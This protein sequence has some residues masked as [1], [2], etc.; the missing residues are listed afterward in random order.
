MNSRGQNMRFVLF[1]FVLLLFFA[2]RTV[3]QAVKLSSTSLSFGNVGVG[4]A[5]SALGVVLTNTDA[6]TPLA[7]AGIAAS[8]DYAES[9]NCNGLVKPRGTCTLLI[10]F[11]PNVLGTQA[12]VVTLTDDAN[13]SPQLITTTGNGVVVLG[14]SKGS[15][16][17][18]TV[19][20]GSTS[21]PQTVTVTNNLKQTATIE[22][23]TSGDYEVAGSGASP[24]P[25][26]GGLAA[27][28]SCTLAVTFQPTFAATISG[29]LTV[30]Q[31]FTSTP[32]IVALS[33]TGSGGSTPPLTFTPTSVSFIATPLGTT[34]T[35]QVTV[36]NHAAIAL[37]IS[38]YSASGDFAVQGGN[39]S[40]CGGLLGAG[41]QC[42]ILVNFSPAT[43]GTIHG[44]LTISSNGSVKTQVINLTGV[45]TLP[46]TVSPTS[47][48]FSSLQQGTSASRTVTLTNHLKTTL[49][50]TDVTVSGDYA[51][52]FGIPPFCGN[53]LAASASCT[54]GVTFSPLARTGTITGALTV[55]S[56][57]SSSPLVVP[58]TGSAFGRLPRFAYVANSNDN[59]LS[60]YSVNYRTGQL[61]HNGYVLTGTQ[62]IS[63]V[64]HPSGRFVYVA[65]FRDHTISGFAINSAGRLTPL[66]GSPFATGTR[67]VSLSITPSG[68]FAYVTN[69]LDNTVSAYAVNASTGVLTAVAGSPF[70][71][72]TQPEGGVIHPSGKFFYVANILDNT[73]SAYSIGGTGALTAV[74][75]SPFATGQG[76]FTI[77]V[78]ASGKFAYVLNSSDNTVSAYTINTTTGALTRIATYATDVFPIR[79]AVDHSGRFLY[80][81]NST[82]QDIS[83]YSIDST[84]GAL[85]PLAGSPFATA[86]KFPSAVAI[87]ASNHFLYSADQGSNE[88][89]MYSI[90]P[91]TGALNLARIVA[92][93]SAPFAMD[94]SSGIA[95][96]TYTP[97]FVYAP[98]RLSLNLISAFAVSPSTGALT[99]IPSSPFPGDPFGTG[100]DPFGRFVYIA[101]DA[102]NN[103]FAYRVNP[104]S[105][106]LT[107]ILGSPVGTGQLPDAVAVDPSGRF[108]YV[109]NF[110][111]NS[112]S[113]YSINQ[114]TGALTEIS[115]SP[116]SLPTSSPPGSIA[117]DPTGRFLYTSNEEFSGSTPGICAFSIDP[118]SG[119][120]AGISGSPFAISGSPGT[121]AIE[122]TGR[123]ALVV[124]IESGP[125]GGGVL[126]PYAIDSSTGALTLQ[127]GFAAGLSSSYLTVEPSG[128]VIFVND[129]FVDIIHEYFLDPLG[130]ISFGMVPETEG[131]SLS[132]LRV[133]I[134]GQFL[135]GVQTATAVMG[136]GIDSSGNLTPI[137]GASIQSAGAAFLAVTGI[138]H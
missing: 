87:D 18:G 127:P 55:T 115:G 62:P 49:S 98:Q 16:A 65:N 128:H 46:V 48:S 89:S 138:V 2:P 23:S 45:G 12:G 99:E 80:V 66:S 53:S 39:T 61:R 27:L 90:N 5:S 52:T 76:P 100:A 29:A 123:F 97:R 117:I 22:V 24:C 104:T 118:T 4:T 19:A 56:S 133:D 85:T 79:A 68:Q 6:V 84:T 13:N 113:A 122:P 96:V 111:S 42:T 36:T 126:W 51:T 135:Y 70:L 3:G 60:E 35:Q 112:V 63:V 64:I 21:L 106:V 132:N 59:T 91:S 131:A 41:K 93:R 134:S 108:V 38:G 114:A 121:I 107:E 30:T 58:L 15:L 25:I 33:G 86:G 81:L 137:P 136:F 94:M 75:G 119:V 7:I 125:L 103:V 26:F 101:N 105:G 77:T 74:T 124:A 72:G 88:V 57:A 109:S 95:P 11:K 130:N 120:L 28:A 31:N 71:T 40:P 37:D 20:V 9:D 54:I 69:D 67:P 73:I 78:H 43:T 129:N 50:I 102:A 47:L 32:L 17:F 83:A 82:G 14:A 1:S 116:F 34:N 92:T 8:G 10:T 44:V 110:L